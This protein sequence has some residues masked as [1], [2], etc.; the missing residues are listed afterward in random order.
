MDIEHNPPSNEG[1]KFSRIWAA[2]TLSQF[3]SQL[4]LFALPIIAAIILNSSPQQISYLVVAE[5]APSL[6]FGLFVGVWVDR[7]EKRKI[8]IYSNFLRSIFL[9]IIPISAYLG[10]LE[11]AHLYIVAFFVGI[12][13]VFYDVA[14]WT[15][16]SS[17]VSPGKYLNSNSKLAFSRSSADMS[18]PAISGFLIQLITAPFVIIFDSVS[19]LISGLLFLTLPKEKV[20]E[21]KSVI[22]TNIF[23]DIFAGLAKIKND[24]IISSLIW[25]AFTWNFLY[26]VGW[27]VFILYLTRV[28]QLDTWEIGIVISGIGIGYLIGS[29]VNGVVTKRIGLGKSVVASSLICALVSC[30]L[31]PVSKYVAI[32]EVITLTVLLTIFG[33]SAAVYNI[34]QFTIRQLTVSSEYM[35]RINAVFRFSTW[36]AIPIGALLGGIIAEIYSIEVAILSASLA[37]LTSALYSLISSPLYDFNRPVDDMSEAQSNSN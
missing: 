12:V 30:L 5:T 1:K 16:I 13:T 6:I 11:I 37:G 34:N 20:Q 31:L 26:N 22:K 29:L 19:F 7:F 21:K 32:G 25:R 2:Y 8:L 9:L 15:Y 33:L 27:V 3:G 17:A 14:F 24:K 28:I 36:S 10:S 18:A 23:T 4:T 35:G